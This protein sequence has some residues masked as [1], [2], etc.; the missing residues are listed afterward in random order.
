MNLFENLVL[1]LFIAA[2]LLAA[3]R[4]LGLPYPTLLCLAGVGAAFLPVASTVGLDPHIALAIF[5]AP[6]LLDAAFDTAPRDLKRLWVPLLILAVGAVIAT[7]IVAAYIGWRY[8]GMPLAAAVALGAI[9]APPDAVAS[10]AG[11]GQTA[12]PPHN[13]LGLR[14]QSLLTDA[15]ALL[16]FGAAV[17]IAGQSPTSDHLVRLGFAVPGGILFGIG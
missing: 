3:S 10:T 16:I 7:T 4:R 14:G 2:V 17:A 8:A 6:A 13:S 1:L 15:T 11:L 5:I 12:L 9:V